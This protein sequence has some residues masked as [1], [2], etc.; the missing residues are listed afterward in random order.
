MT[1]DELVERAV[2]WL[3]KTRRCSI[4]FAEMT[5]ILMYIPD[6]IGWYSG[7]SILV[8]CK[9]S[10]ADF[11]ADLK[12]PIHAAPDSFPGQER[13]YLTTPRLVTPDEIPGEWGLLEAH[14]TM[15][16][17]VKKAEHFHGWGGRL[18]P[19]RCAEEAT[20][21]LSAVRRHQL[22][23]DWNHPRARFANIAGVVRPPKTNQR[24]LFYPRAHTRITNPATTPPA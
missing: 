13:W 14:P 23:V 9:R 5:T 3:R 21:L 1:H 12:K 10:R 4:V 22:G 11:R 20:L 7:R 8:E 16:R 6:A 24:D 17:V 18:S 2:R 15:A 19:E